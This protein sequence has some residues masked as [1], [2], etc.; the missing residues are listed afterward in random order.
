MPVLSRFGFPGYLEDLE[1][2]NC[3]GWSE[4]V[5]TMVGDFVEVFPQFYDPTAD[6][7]PDALE[8]VNIAWG[9]FPARVLREEGHGEAAWARAD[10]AREEQDEYCEWC[11][12]RDSAGDVTCVTFTTELPEYWDYVAGCD[13]DRLLALYRKLVD[14]RVTLDDLLEGGRYVG[15]N[16][17][18]SSTEG[19]PAHLI[20]AN[21]TLSAA[22]QL[23]AEAT[24]LCER[25]DGT[26]VTDRQE[27]VVR[28]Q[29][30]NPFRN[31]DP[32]IAEV[33]NRAAARGDEIAVFDPCGL[34]IDAFLSSGMTTP[35]DTDASQF[36]KVERGT[37]EHAVRAS[38]SVPPER[39]YT[40]SDIQIRGRRISFGAQVAERV[41][42]RC[43]ALAKPAGRTPIRRRRELPAL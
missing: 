11:V 39:G 41:R 32:Q 26:L 14:A 24:I 20:Q 21:N 22:I 10:S 40:V 4:T 6:D 18:N 37:P 3:A 28:A 12:E 7:T 29:L 38:F 9:A 25:P 43:S 34:Y 31:S 2:A 19:R 30:G 42:V 8:P 23:M 16:R 1:E 35:D 15:P 5:A 13:P 33:V 27:L 36:W 17:W